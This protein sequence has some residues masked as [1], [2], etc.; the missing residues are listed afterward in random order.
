MTPKESPPDPKPSP[1]Q[2]YKNWCD[3]QPKIRVTA[4]FAGLLGL[5]AYLYLLST[6]RTIEQ[7]LGGVI[8]LL[9]ITFV[10]AWTAVFIRNK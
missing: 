9:I 6:A 5:F 7:L 4:Y 10:I 3:R 2:V 1:W 8:L